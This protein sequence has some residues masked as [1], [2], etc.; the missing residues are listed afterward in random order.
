MSPSR[1]ASAWTVVPQAVAVVVLAFS[2]ASCGERDPVASR[3][4]ERGA[5]VVE[6]QSFTVRDDGT[7]LVEVEVRSSIGPVVE[8][9]TVTVRQHD[10]E[11]QILRQDRVPF[12][13]SGMDATG[14]VRLYATVASAGEMVE[15]LSAVFEYAP[16]EADYDQFP[17]IQEVLP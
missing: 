5:H 6:V 8:T 13:L 2:S 9:L 16:P 14:V 4:Q 11:R 17:E 15:T 7:I 12:D 1:S 10:A 3:L